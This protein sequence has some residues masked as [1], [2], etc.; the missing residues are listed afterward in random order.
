MDRK[1]GYFIKSVFRKFGVIVFPIQCMGI[2]PLFF[3]VYLMWKTAVDVLQRKDNQVVLS[4]FII[5]QRSSFLFL[6]GLVRWEDAMR[7]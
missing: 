6:F 4:C 7:L 5:G 3:D 1:D 2:C